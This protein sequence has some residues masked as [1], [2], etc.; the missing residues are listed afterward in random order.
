MTSERS[1]WALGVVVVDV[2]AQHADEVARAED[3]QPVQA[4]RACGSNEALGIGVGLRRAER[5]QDHLDALGAKDLV[6]GGDELRVAVAD[7][8]PDIA[9]GSREAEVA[10]LLGDPAAVGIRSRAP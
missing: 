10:R 7:E 4:L 5:R 1:V 9:E 8:E 6:E 2:D 3:Q